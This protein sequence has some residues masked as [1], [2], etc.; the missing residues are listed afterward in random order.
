MVA[1]D[2][3]PT[4]IRYAEEVEKTEPLGVDYWVA[5]AMALPFEPSSF[6]FARHWPHS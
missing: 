6:D 3:A 5:D 1:I 2:V 4:F